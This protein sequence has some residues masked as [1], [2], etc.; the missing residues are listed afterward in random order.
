MTSKA[1]FDNQI[2]GLVMKISD[3]VVISSIDQGKKSQTTA[4]MV[5]QRVDI[6]N[7][8]KKTVLTSYQLLDALQIG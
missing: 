7:Q 5:A 6:A 1:I 4:E 8:I 3:L 2:M